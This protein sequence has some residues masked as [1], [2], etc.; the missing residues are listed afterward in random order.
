MKAVESLRSTGSDELLK[1][2]VVSLVDAV[3]DRML[4][5]EFFWAES[6]EMSE[7]VAGLS[8]EDTLEAT[9]EATFE[10]T[11]ELICCST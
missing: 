1:T 10:F 5:E 7:L 11:S 6:V 2:D 3:S 4:A 9:F 8:V